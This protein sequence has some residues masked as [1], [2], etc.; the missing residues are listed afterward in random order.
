MGHDRSGGTAVS[1]PSAAHPAPYSALAQV[2]DRWMAAD[3]IPYEQWLAFTERRFAEAPRSVRTVLDLCCGTGTTIRSLQDAGYQVIGVDASRQMLDVA[4]SRVAPGT[5]LAQL[6]LPDDELLRL[7]RVDAVLMCFDG[8]NYLTGP[9][10]LPTVLRQAASLLEPGGVLVFDLS[11]RSTFESIAGMGEFGEEFEDFAYRWDTTHEPGSAHYVY[12]VTLLHEGRSETEL[13]P[14]RWFSH[15]EVATAL[16]AAGFED[17]AVRDD[18][19]EAA[20]GPTTRRD[21]WSAR[22]VQ[23]HRGEATS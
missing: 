4:R 20:A 17:I 18:Y 2:Y 22:A 6:T 7:G 15:H 3:R 9:D 21:T 14:Q 12:R 10:D 1:A 13:H 19:T 23:P 8:A 5:R 16:A 11:T